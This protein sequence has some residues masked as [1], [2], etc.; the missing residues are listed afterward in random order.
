MR[1]LRGWASLILGTCDSA[2]SKNKLAQTETEITDIVMSGATQRVDVHPI[3]ECVPN[4]LLGLPRSER[5]D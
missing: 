2:T 4:G 1:R 3:V 5:T